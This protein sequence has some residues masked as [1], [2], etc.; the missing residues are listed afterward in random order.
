M[1][2]TNLPGN[3]AISQKALVFINSATK[4]QIMLRNMFT[5]N[6]LELQENNDHLKYTGVPR[7]GI[8]HGTHR[9]VIGKIKM[10]FLL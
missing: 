9:S 6:I 1:L 2:V 7:H 4:P 3:N 10:S 5:A 8:E